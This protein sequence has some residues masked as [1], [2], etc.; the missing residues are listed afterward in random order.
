MLK[1]CREAEAEL[2]EVTSSKDLPV[3]L[4]AFKALLRKLPA[5]LG[6]RGDYVGPHITRKY[7]LGVAATAGP[8]I[9]FSKLS[10]AQLKAMSPDM[11]GSLD[12]VPC[13]MTPCKLARAIQCP[14]EHITMWTCLWSEPLLKLPGSYEA[15][16]SRTE[17]IRAELQRY[18]QQHGF[19]P[20]PH[21][22]MELVL[23]GV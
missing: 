2:T 11:R 3:R 19:P 13:V 6:M 18:S 16:F 7:M 9:T 12:K 17:D 21:R 8:G 22:L 5:E 15:V 1:K 23:N 10:K 20:S 14:A 4:E